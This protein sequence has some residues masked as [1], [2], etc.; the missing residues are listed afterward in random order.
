[1]K[2]KRARSVAAG[3][4]G[5]GLPLRT[6]GPALLLLALAA[7][8]L[9]GQQGPS[10][11]TLEEAIDLARRNN[12]TYLSTQND[13]SAAS[14]QE[15]EAYA[16]FLPSLNA[17]FGTTWQDAGTQRFGTF[18]VAQ[19]TEWFYSG[20]NLSLGMTIDGNA[21]FAIPNARANKRASR[22]P[23]STSAPWSRSST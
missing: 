17:S 16:Q 5:A 9:A 20:Y 15:R 21:I 13:M 2:R 10:S 8:A 11:L 23:S 6:V 18:E 4:A 14:W 3:R 19:S 1:M 22:R 12:P 7:A